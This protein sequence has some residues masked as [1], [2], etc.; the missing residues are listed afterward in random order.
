MIHFL[1]RIISWLR[2]QMAVNAIRTQAR[3]DGKD[4]LGR[5]TGQDIDTLIKK[6]RAS[7][8]R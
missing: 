1:I 6:S 5:L 7:R 2:A 4:G 3:K 8:K